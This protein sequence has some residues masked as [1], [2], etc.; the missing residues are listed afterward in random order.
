M[1]MKSSNNILLV[2]S[3]Q[4]PSAV[5]LMNGE[6]D[7]VATAI[8]LSIKKDFFSKFFFKLFLFFH[9]YKIAVFFRAKKNVR[10]ALKSGAFQ[11]VVFFDCS[12][13]REY[14]VFGG[15]IKEEQKKFIYFWNPIKYRCANEKKALMLLNRLKKQDFIL[16]TFEKNDSKNYGLSFLKS[17]NRKVRF[18]RSK[19]VFDFYFAGLPKGRELLLESLKNSLLKKGFSVK[20]I[21]VR[22][23]DDCVSQE[24]NR[25]NSENCKCIVDWVSEDYGQ[26]NLSL[27]ST[28]ALLLEKKII[29][30]CKAILDA[31]F[32][33]PSN[34]FLVKDLNLEGIESFMRKPYERVS[35]DIVDSYEI[36]NWLKMNF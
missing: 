8:M 29:T 16:K 34:V 6:D 31:D 17:P 2:Y 15:L 19:E 13:L 33:N 30:N 3:E 5:F 22:S 18:N 1:Q 25:A 23:K 32:Y 4:S 20:F 7:S 11:R 35:K 36:N 9:L 12:P 10:D 26:N 24:E 21:I 28:D 14:A 27:R